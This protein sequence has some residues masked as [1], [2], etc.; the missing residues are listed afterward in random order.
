MSVRVF[1]AD[2]GTFI[3]PKTG[4][5]ISVEELRKEEENAYKDS[6]DGAE[7]ASTDKK[8]LSRQAQE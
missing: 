7:N 4:K 6:G 2:S 1:T 8:V 3:D 5:V